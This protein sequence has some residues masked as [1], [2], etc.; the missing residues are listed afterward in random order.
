LFGRTS[1]QTVQALITQNLATVTKLEWGKGRSENAKIWFVMHPLEQEILQ[2][3]RDSAYTDQRPEGTIRLLPAQELF[4]IGQKWGYRKEEIAEVIKLLSARQYVTYNSGTNSIE[5]LIRSVD[6]LRESLAEGLAAAEAEITSLQVV[7]DFN[8]QRYQSRLGRI[9][10]SVQQLE[11]AEDAEE[12][13]ATL[14][15]VEFG[16]RK[17]IATAIEKRFAELRAAKG[18]V[19]PLL[20]AGVPDELITAIVGG[21]APW[22]GAL[23][24]SRQRLRKRYDELI[25]KYKNLAQDVEKSLSDPGP[26]EARSDYLVELVRTHATFHEQLEQLSNQR[27][28]MSAN[29][30]NLRAWKKLLQRSNQVHQGAVT[31]KASFGEAKFLDAAEGIWHQIA[32][33]FKD[34][35]LDTLSDHEIFSKD[36]AELEQEIGDWQRKRRE[37]FMAEKQGLENALRHVGD[38]RPML[39][40]NFDPYVS[41]EEGRENLRQEAVEHFQGILTQYE[42]QYQQLHSEVIY[43]E[44]VQQVSGTLSADAVSTSLAKARELKNTVTIQTLS[45][46]TGLERLTESIAGLRDTLVEMA[47]TVQTFITKRPL[48]G[49][50]ENTLLCIIQENAA[51][52]TRG[53]ELKHVILKLVA[54]NP[55]FQI[56]QVMHDLQSLFKKNQVIIRIEPRR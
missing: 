42:Q 15:N 3:L 25:G 18:K 48:E 44:R 5:Q 13:H 22:S 1:K 41:P 2:L 51:D 30:S 40:T 52:S 55:E 36:V 19:Q 47:T 35:P 7:T 12:L 10:T 31:A 16:L 54:D 24:D 21:Q 29:Q 34:A 46:D 45:D 32:K 20:S 56:E 4:E 27:A 49:E 53:V 9:R 39:K 23:E 38:E 28:A 26:V 33:E 37:D 8:L 6:D 17:Y 43:A 50:G 14:R 11:K